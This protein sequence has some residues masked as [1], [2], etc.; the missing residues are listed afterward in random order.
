MTVAVPPH[1]AI[2]WFEIGSAEPDVAEEFYGGLFGWQFTGGRSAGFDYRDIS[3]GP[4]H[5][6]RGGLLN[7]EGRAP[8][9]AVFVVLVD[10]VAVTCDETRRLGGRVDLGPVMTETGVVCAYLSDPQGNRF[11]VFTPPGR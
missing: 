9:Y 1:G 6:V 3:T 11:A 5:P 8:G 2:G 10:D 7:T 4:E